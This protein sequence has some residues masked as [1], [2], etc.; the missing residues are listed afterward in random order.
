[1]HIANLLETYLLVCNCFLGFSNLLFLSFLNIVTTSVDFQ[2]SG[3]VDSGMHLFIF[4]WSASEKISVF[5]S[6]IDVGTLFFRSVLESSVF[7]II[8]A[9]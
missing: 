6:M 7:L 8:K 1:M 3:N 5:F 4:L 9:T 2:S